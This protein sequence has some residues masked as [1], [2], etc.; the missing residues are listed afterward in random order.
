[1]EKYAKKIISVEEKDVLVEKYTPKI[2][3]EVKS[4]I[5][6]CCIKLLT[7]DRR[8]KDAWEDNF[9]AMSSNIR[10]HGR[11]YVIW[12]N[13][14]PENLVE[15]DPFSKTAFIYNMDYYG[16][17]K[18]I[19]LGVTGDILEDEH[20]IYSVHGACLDVDGRG[21]SIMGTSGM[22]KTT[23]TYGLLRFKHV[24]VI[25]DDW[26]FVRL[27]E[28]SALCFSSE[29]NFYI[30]ADLAKIWKE[31]EKFMEY[32]QFDEK[33]RGI[34]NLRQVVGK[35]RILPATTAQVTVILIR[36]KEKPFVV[37]QIDPEEALEITVSH[38]FFNPHLLVND[39]RKMRIRREFFK[40]FFELSTVYVVNT[41]TPPEV[42]NR[43]ILK[44]VSGGL[45]RNE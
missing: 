38:S 20:G 43:N 18:S 22:G 40:K 12:D 41:V 2:I 44:L 33:G 16:W 39:E 11:V 32:V 10:S 37:K 8:I 14:K 7:W 1:M 9:Y 21:L 6:G 17:I 34:L 42:T 15:Y 5:Y 23:Q 27:F 25:A 30:R 3:Y 24:R 35:G 19:A 13:E 36:D 45:E 26:F 29:K 28:D 31:Y 4:D